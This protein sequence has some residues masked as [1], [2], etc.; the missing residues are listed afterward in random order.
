MTWIAFVHG[1][2][3]AK[4]PIVTGSRHVGT[5]CDRTGKSP[6]RV[7][8]QAWATRTCKSDQSGKCGDERI[9]GVLHRDTEITRHAQLL[10]ELPIFHVELHQRLRMVRDEGDR[11]HQHRHPVERGPLDLGIGAGPDPLLRRRTRLVADHPV[12]L[13]FAP[14]RQDAGNRLLDLPLIRVAA[15]HH[16]FRQPVGG[17]QHAQPDLRIELCSCRGVGFAQQRRRGGDIVGIGRIAA[18]RHGVRHK[19]GSRCGLA[20]C[21]ERTARRRGRIMRIERQQHD[22]V[23]LPVPYGLRRF[24]AQRMPVAHRDEAFGVKFRQRGL[25]RR[26]L[27]LRQLEQRRSAA[28]QGIVRGRWL[29]PASRDVTRQ[30]GTHKE[31]D[32]QD[33]RVSEQIQQEGFDR[34]RPIGPSQIEQHHGDLRPHAP[35]PRASP[36]VSAASEARCRAQG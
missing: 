33:S 30:D 12:R 21:G 16:D 29:Q 10:R 14:F 13:R 35:T 1:Y 36:H 8:A 7:A 22:L 18:D 9:V 34:L 17:E 19:A 3:H 5:G 4:K 24:V 6:T 11:H 27:R 25:E 20:P 31:W 32:T 28:K 26:R 23:R 2:S 15:T